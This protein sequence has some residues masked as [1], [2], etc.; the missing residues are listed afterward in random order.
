VCGI[1]CSIYLLEQLM[2]KLLAGLALCALTGGATAEIT[3]SN[4][5]FTVTTPGLD[6]PDV[7][8][9]EIAGNSVVFGANVFADTFP[10]GLPDSWQTSFNLAFT[11]AAGYAIH[12]YDL[13]TMVSGYVDDMPPGPENTQFGSAS[14]SL[15]LT[16]GGDRTYQPGSTFDELITFHQDGIL[17]APGYI[18]LYAEPGA[19]CSVPL[20]ICSDPGPGSHYLNAGV[21]VHT[22]TITPVIVAVPEPSTY[23]LLAAGLVALGFKRKQ[24]HGST[25]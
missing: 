15:F 5:K 17:L 14:A 13:V 21:F 25:R 11:P 12:G 20:T 18:E 10:R 4:D 2:K 22:V 24:A 3:L 8:T 1:A 16:F 9:L 6:L 19:Y 23:A 7:Q